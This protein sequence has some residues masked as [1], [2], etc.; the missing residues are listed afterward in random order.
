MRAMSTS[1]SKVSL[2]FVQI[3][4]NDIKKTDPE[5][6]GGPARRSFITLLICLLPFQPLL[7]APTQANL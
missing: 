4:G 2:N 5:M 3:M 7:V 1:V 6:M